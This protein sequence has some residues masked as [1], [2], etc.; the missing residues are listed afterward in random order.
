MFVFFSPKK[1]AEQLTPGI[2]SHK[3]PG[4]TP[5]EAKVPLAKN[6]NQF[7]RPLV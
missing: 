7:N 4:V 5:Q 3:V 6:G 1:A 2:L